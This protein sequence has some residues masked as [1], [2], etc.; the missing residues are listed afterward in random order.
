MSPIDTKPL[1]AQQKRLAA[2][3]SLEND[4]PPWKEIRTVAG[5]DVSCRMHGKTGYGAIVVLAYPGLEVIEEQTHIDGLDFP[6]IP[7]LLSFRELPILLKCWCKLERK[8]DVV[9]CDAQGIAHPRR[10]G[11]AA[12]FGVE[13]GAITVGC[14]KS[15]LVGEYRE[16]GYRR[17]CRTALRFNGE[18]IGEVVRTRDGV[19]PLFVSP[20]HRIDFDHASKL[21]LRLASRFRQSEPIRAAHRLVNELREQNDPLGGRGES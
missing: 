16:P 17:G 11:L 15:L 4:L 10:I 20:G 18:K 9:I 6:Y 14:A 5:C 3:V 21:V 2:R 19:K 7:G 1:A 8:P 12:H 13:S